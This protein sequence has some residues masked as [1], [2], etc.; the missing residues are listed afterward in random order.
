LRCTRSFS[1]TT[2]SKVSNSSSLSEGY[3]ERSRR[4][5]Q[6]EFVK[7][8]PEDNPDFFDFPRERVGNNM[9][10]NWALHEHF[11]A[12]ANDAFR[13]LYQRALLERIPKIGNLSQQKSKA[14]PNYYLK[15]QQ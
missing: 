9:D 2:S 7:S 12:P 10:L 11:V 1:T 14:N 5:K 15:T 4:L 3:L 6:R 13:N 8:P